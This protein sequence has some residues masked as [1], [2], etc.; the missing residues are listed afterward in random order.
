MRVA[1]SRLTGA[2]PKGVTAVSR[3]SSLALSSIIRLV[4]SLAAFALAMYGFKQAYEQIGGGLTMADYAYRSLQLVVGQ[5]P[6]EL[7]GRQQ[8]PL[9]LLI[10]RW[11]LPLVTFWA[12]A[13][14]AWRQV[15]NPIRAALIRMRG[16]HLVLAGDASVAGRVAAGELAAKR[17]VLIWTK[18]PREQW[19][20]DSADLGAAN[21]PDV[22]KLGL[23]KARSVLIAGSDDAANIALAGACVDTALE[24]RLAGDPLTIIARIDDPDLRAPLERRYDWGNERS[25]VRMRFASLPDIGAREMFV[26]LPLDRFQR[27]DVVD[28]GVF[29]VGFSPT[30]ERYVVRLLAA[31]HFSGGVRPRIVVLDTD[32]AR[33]R[34]VFFARRPGA[35]ALAPVV[36]EEAAV[37]QPALIGQAFDAAIATY[38]APTAVFVDP[39]DSARA[40]TVALAVEERFRQS[41]ALAPPI[42]LRLPEQTADGDLSCEVTPIGGN[43][44]LADPELLLQERL[45][46]LARSTHEFYLEGRLDEGDQIGSR[47]SMYEW[48]QLTENFRDENRLTADCFVLKLR[49]VGAR[50]VDGGDA[51]GG[52][53]FETDELEALSRAEH[54]RWMASKLIDGWKF[55]ARR[56]D[57]AKIHPDIVPYDDL[58]EARKDLDREQIKIVTR[59]L[60]TTGRR[61][62]RDLVIALDSSG[63]GPLVSKTVLDQIAAQ[64]PDRALV[65]LGA[66]DDESARAGLLAA[67][68]LG[69]NVQIT[70]SSEPE[71]LLARRPRGER[72]A[73]RRLYR[74][75]DRIFA[76]PKDAWPADKRDAFMLGR[77]DLRLTASAVAGKSDIPTVRVDGRGQIAA[78]PWTR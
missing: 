4:L 53:R 48:D 7:I 20:Q 25:L 16:E 74:Q 56:D 24:Q 44:S 40:L 1:M 62:V 75:A 60:G 58:T 70:V 68:D 27:G 28:R 59:L 37:D 47:G 51:S 11:A 21:V 73:L 71:G 26:R 30:V 46:A 49:D 72:A 31:A 2:A 45:D 66:F 5:F 17:P 14:L 41:G 76:L 50:L 10:A 9:P 35:A 32:A 36:F 29:F 39:H 19:V 34:E 43:D 18:E 33:K 8:L 55:G 67:Q 13:T 64:Y 61:A 57:A 65:V 69:V 52:F 23:A 38:G 63:E 6:A 78:A 54:D 22:A 12:T 3:V 15:R 42:Y 77:A